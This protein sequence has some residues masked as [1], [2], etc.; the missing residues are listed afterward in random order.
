MEKYEQKLRLPKAGGVTRGRQ[1]NL[2]LLFLG[3]TKQLKVNV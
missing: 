1:K 3:G 2:Q